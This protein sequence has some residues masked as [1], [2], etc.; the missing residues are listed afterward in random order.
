MRNILPVLFVF[1]LAL[2]FWGAAEARPSGEITINLRA[3]VD[4]GDEACLSQ[5][6]DIEV[7]GAT[8]CLRQ[9]GE[10]EQCFETEDGEMWLDSLPHGSYWA[11]GVAPAG[12]ELANI[13][14]TTFPNNPY[15]PCQVRGSEVHFVVKKYV[16]ETV[17]A[18]SIN[19]LLVP[20]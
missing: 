11:R 19:F 13:T 16:G 17:G 15:S 8:V 2:A 3:C 14:C 6:G 18:V 12:Y 5:P 1:V 20:N 4:A 10:Q 9:S 7:D